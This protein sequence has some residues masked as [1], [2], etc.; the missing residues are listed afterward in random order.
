MS[1]P[2]IIATVT[3]LLAASGVAAWYGLSPS[4]TPDGTTT[5]SYDIVDS[6]LARTTIAVY[7]DETRDIICAVRAVN[8]QEASVG[9]TEVL[10]PADPAA[11]R[12]TPTIVSTDIATTQLA[13]SGHFESCWYAD[14]PQI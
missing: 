4:P 5:V 6:T 2:A 3:A 10:I 14:D 9:F 11:D 1:R 8:A 12:S 13:A 7:P